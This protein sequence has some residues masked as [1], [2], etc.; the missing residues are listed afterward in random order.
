MP[1]ELNELLDAPKST[2]RPSPKYDHPVQSQWFDPE[3]GLDQEADYKDVSWLLA[4]NNSSGS[5]KLPAWTGFNGIVS[6]VES[7]KTKVGLLPLINAP[8]HESHTM[9]TV[10]HRCLK[11][12]EKLNPG[13]SIVLTL[14]QQLYS[15][16]KE[17][18]WCRPEECKSLLV[19]LGSF[20]TALN[21]MRVIGQHF[22]D[23]G[24]LEVWT[25]S[26]VYGENTAN[27]IIAAKSYNKAMRAHK[28][29]YE[30]VWRLYQKLFLDWLHQKEVDT[31]TINQSLSVLSTGFHEQKEPDKLSQMFEDVV[32]ALKQKQILCLI[33]D[34]DKEN[35]NPTFVYWRQ[36]M[37]LVQILLRFTKAE[38]EG[39]WT[40]H[41]SS[42]AAM[43]PWFAVYGHTNYTRW[44]AIYL[45][46]MKNIEET[47]PDIFTEFVN[48][49]FVLKKTGHRF[50]QISTDQA[51]EHV[52][53]ICKVAGG[54][55]GITRLESARERWCLTLNQRSDISQ[56]TM[57]M[58]GLQSDDTGKKQK[59]KEIGTSRIRRDEEDVKL[60]EQQLKRFHLFSIDQ[61]DLVALASQDVAPEDLG[62]ALL[63][64]ESRG[65]EKMK[66]F[67]DKRL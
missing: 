24:L 50:N 26:G 40:L 51:L 41:L 6:R 14:D 21:C 22:T 42:F 38:R 25:E 12:S 28:L 59:S 48:G 36:Y 17:L 10:I 61:Q 49:S 45:A 62:N 8:A 54:L 63:N 31:E 27:N 60:L 52:N 58:Y 65:K 35:Q 18:Q 7:D 47:H 32:D 15:K 64:A 19:R 53:R 43:L 5:Q 46:D 11:I 34:F 55:I 66:L 37:R 13:Q 39:N 56:Q 57:D 30:A 29:T 67:V 3:S 20:H 23:S 44:G 2:G 4:R 16:A 1:C 9:W 33:E